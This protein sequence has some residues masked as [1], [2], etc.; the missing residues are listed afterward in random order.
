MPG[1]SRAATHVHHVVYRSHGGGDDLA[2]MVSMCAGRHLHCLHQG[3]I[4]V[5]G[6]APDRL[7][8]E[9]AGDRSGESPWVH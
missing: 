6:Q 8:W 5:R 7:V 2:N 1:C 4:R 3:W 9:M